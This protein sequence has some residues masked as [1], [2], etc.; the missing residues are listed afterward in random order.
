MGTAFALPHART[1]DLVAAV[2][3][4]GRQGVAT[5]ALTPGDGARDIDDVRPPARCAIVVGAEREGL[6]PAMLAACWERVRI[7]LAAGV[8]SLN[9]AAATA[10]ACHALRRR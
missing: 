5:Y 6:S 9:V 8:D 4:L 3:E 1:D 7:P 2:A 10:I